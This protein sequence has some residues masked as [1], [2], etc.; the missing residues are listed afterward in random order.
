MNT[1]FRTAAWLTLAALA[2]SAPAA[3]QNLS[4]SVLRP[5]AVDPATGL[6]AGPFPGGDGATS[7]YLTLDLQPG[8]LMT[9]LQVAGRANTPKRIDFELL[10][11]NART[12]GSS[13]V[14]GELEAKRDVTKSFAIDSAGRY[15]IRL[16]VDGKE[17]NTF[18]VLMGGT[19]L[20][21]VRSPGCPAPA[22]AAAP[23]PIRVAPPPVRVEPVAPPPPVVVVAPPPPPP[24]EAAKPVEVIV[25]RCEERLRVGSD[26]LFDF[27][28]YE[29]RPEADVALSEVAARI[30]AV[31]K[32]VLIEGHTD[33]KGTESYNQT[34]SERRA[35]A[36]RMALAGRGLPTEWLRTRGLG[37]SRPVA[38]NERADG[39]DDPD[40]RQRN[41]RVEIVINTCS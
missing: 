22:A 15:V 36:V 30:Q 2:L 11:A 41:R 14:M 25:S 13:W 29:V 40:G 34:L 8:S 37:K 27:D 4:T 31:H 16:V 12:A 28:R 1:S 38:P 33:A 21:N 26:F 7:Y 10:D 32:A 5:T 18:C 17:S 6:V 23:A 19:A 3:A 9:Q 39:S 24:V 35:G 20:P